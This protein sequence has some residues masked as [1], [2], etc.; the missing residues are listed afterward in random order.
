VLFLLDRA[1]LE[2]VVFALL[3]LFVYLYFV[4]RSPWSW[5][6]LSLAIAGKYFWVVFLVLLATDRQWRQL[7]LTA[8]SAVVVTAAS[9][10]LLAVVSGLS[11]ADVAGSTLGTLGG[12][13]NA[14]S[15]AQAIQHG[16]SFFAVPY[17]VDRGAGYWL[18][19]HTSLGELY[20]FA[21]LALLLLVGVRLALYEVEPWCK[22]TALVICAI[23]LPFESHDYT[24]V[25]LLLPLALLG[26]WG[27]KSTHGRLYAILFGLLLVP[28][29]YVQFGFLVSYSSLA[30]SILLLVLLVAVLSDVGA[31]QARPWR[32]RWLH[33]GDTT[34]AGGEGRR[35]VMGAPGPDPRA[36]ADAN[37]VGAPRLVTEVD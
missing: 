33:A 30:Y 21:A 19:M 24:L 3:A 28:L 9:F 29:D 27:A 37:A 17:F 13:A 11:F 7:V 2:M 15:S 4:R 23:A 36:R 22:L 34:D 32:A 16:H 26:A 25:H 8:L 1:N 31:P 18:Q 6:P 10:A 20:T 14:A 5:L 12:H 35:V